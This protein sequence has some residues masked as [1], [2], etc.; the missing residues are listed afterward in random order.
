MCGVKCIIAY[1]VCRSFFGAGCGANGSGVV[2]GLFAIG[3][4]HL[5]FGVDKPM[6]IFG[7]G[8][9]NYVDKISEG[10]SA[11]G[12]D[13]VCVLCGDTSWGMSFEECVDDFKFIG[14]L[15]GRKIILKGN[16]DYWWATAAK[17]KAFFVNNGIEGIEILNNNCFFYEDV[18]IC[19][20]RG[21]FLDEVSDAAHSAKIMARET[22]RLRAS[23]VA[24]GGAGVKF[25][26]FHYP[27]RF[28][29]FVCRDI[30]A[31][32]NEFGVRNCWYGHVHGYGHRFAVF[33]EV[34]G[35]AYKMVSADFVDFVPQRVL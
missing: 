2:L 25:C 24:A 7:G 22:S 19:G 17:L 26:F 28:N 8:W 6:D 33:G 5:S 1:G 31:V 13:D 4:L 27:P 3:D 20:T 34:E 32:M 23:L 10:F 11:L 30:I 16:H 12:P 14:G 18:A 15:P 29:D 9:D 21:W 35:I